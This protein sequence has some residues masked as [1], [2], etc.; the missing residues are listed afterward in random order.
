ML[1]E[2]I[3]G[4][5]P[6]TKRVYGGI[7]R[8][9][10]NRTAVTACIDALK[11]IVLPCDITIIINSE[12]VTQAVNSGEWIKWL[13]TGRNAKSKPAKNIDLWQQLFELVDKYH[14]TFEY[15]ASNQYTLCMQSM[16]KK[17][18]IEFKEDE[19]NV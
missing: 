4:K 2:Y 18:N 5:G 9:T 1:L 14:V 11:Q 12:Y 6:A 16:A 17:V 15:A 13:H 8:T 7:K 19:G 10:A 3:T